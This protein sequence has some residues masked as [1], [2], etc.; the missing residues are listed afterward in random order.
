VYALCYASLQ[1]RWPERFATPRSLQ[2]HVAEGRFGT[3]TGSGYLRIPAE[4]TA[5]LVAYRN[6]AYA[7]MRD[8]LDDLGEP[9]T[10]V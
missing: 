2:E 8:L 4:R 10:G 9:P 7:A 5:E 1:T 6:R 3:K